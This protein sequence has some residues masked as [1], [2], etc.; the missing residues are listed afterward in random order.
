MTQGNVVVPMNSYIKNRASLSV[1][2]RIKEVV[3]ENLMYK[4]ID[5]ACELKK[6]D[7]SLIDVLTRLD[8]TLIM[9]EAP[10]LNKP[11]SCSFFIH[12]KAWIFKSDKG[13]YRYYS[14]KKNSIYSFDIIDLLSIFR[15]E[16]KKELFVFLENKCKVFGITDW[17]IKQKA[18][19]NQNRKTLE[20][21]KN[22]PDLYPNLYKILHK[23]WNVLD[24]L[25]IYAIEKLGS[26][27]CSIDGNSVFF[28]SNNHFKQVYEPKRSISTINQIINLICVLGFVQKIPI[29]KIPESML[30]KA[31]IVY[32]QAKTI[33]RTTYYALSDFECVLQKAEYYAKTLNESKIPYHKITKR[34]VLELFGENFCN[35]IYTQETSGMKR[36]PDPI[37]FMGESNTYTEFERLESKFLSE[38]EKYGKCEKTPLEE[39]TI[40]S[41]HRF[42]EIWK[43]LV[44]K[45]HCIEKKPT[46]SEMTFFKMKRRYLIA[47]PKQ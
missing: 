11:F 4:L 2:R 15:N 3:D 32:K 18:R 14:K 10:G 47:I 44:T 31:E 43:A 35:Q 22:N 27:T 37:Y 9:K 20:K 46:N 33:N 24:S 38:I 29:S 23:H 21:L 19:Y 8:L 36:K 7:E 45:H 26:K 42:D 39:S 40:V 17:H 41:H 13:V 1:S 16:T 6:A 30:Q 12:R 34:I 25:N 5:S 28:L